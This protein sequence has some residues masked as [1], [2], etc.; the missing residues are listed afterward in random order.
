MFKLLPFIAGAFCTTAL[1]AGH[2]SDATGTE[3]VP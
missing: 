2:V 3:V 1:F